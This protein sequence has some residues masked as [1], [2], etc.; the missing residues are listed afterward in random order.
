MCTANESHLIVEFKDHYVIKPS[1]NI[2]KNK[3]D[4][5]KNKI[6]EKGKLVKEIFEYNS[7]SNT[8]FLN[9][10]QIKKLIKRK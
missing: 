3:I 1:I 6:G 2:T 5:K 10:N 4:Y 8:D 7:K 9:L